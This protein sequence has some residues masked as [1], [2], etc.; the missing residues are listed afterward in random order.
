VSG[1]NNPY[2]GTWN[3]VLGTLVASGKAA[4]G[5][6]TITIGT[7]GALQANYSINN[8]AGR[9]I[10][11]GRLNLTQTLR[12]NSVS[13]NG[14]MLAPGQYSFAQLNGTYPAN[15]PASWMAQPGAPTTSAS[16]SLIVGLP[17]TLNT[18]WNGVQLDL[19]WA[20]SGKLL[21]ATNL[22]GP[23]LTNTTALSPFPVTPN[24]PQMFYRVQF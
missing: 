1:N 8:P 23:W 11:N 10:L 22:S 12:F 24:A 4:L 2:S 7:N 21:Q 3:V 13:V 20:G 16:G 19:T 5:T 15:F 9:L 6:N 14:T 18:S 17:I